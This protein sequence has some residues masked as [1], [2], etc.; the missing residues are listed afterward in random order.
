MVGA[1]LEIRGTI[2]N[3][4]FTTALAGDGKA[5]PLLVADATTF[6]PLK[7]GTMGAVHLCYLTLRENIEGAYSAPLNRGGNGTGVTPANWIRRGA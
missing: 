6:P 1:L 7:R 5:A 2:I 3:K 4:T